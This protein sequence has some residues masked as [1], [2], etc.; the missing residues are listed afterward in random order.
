[1]LLVAQVDLMRAATKEQFAAKLA[2]AVYEQIATPL[3]RMRDRAAQVFRGLRIH[4]VMTVDAT[5]GTLGFSFTPG[6]AAAELDA[7]LAKLMELG[8]IA[9]TAFAPYI[10]ARFE[11]SGKTVEDSVVEAV[12]V[13]TH[14]HP[15]GT[16][17]LC[18]TLWEET[19]DGETATD[20]SFDA[21]LEQVLRSE[22]A[23]FTRI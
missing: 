1:D 10:R 22:N 14:G 19:P 16:Q 12:L 23:H 4:P 13:V 7:T 5:D 6:H 9:P 15:Y 21:A 2:Q 3:F 11:A 17:E 8:V 20:A 18:Y